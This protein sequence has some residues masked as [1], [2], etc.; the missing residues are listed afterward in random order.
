MESVGL[1]PFLIGR[2]RYQILLVSFILL[3]VFSA[4]SRTAAMGAGP[5][6]LIGFVVLF[7]AVYAMRGHRLHL[8]GASACTLI[9]IVAGSLAVWTEAPARLV[10]EV[11]NWGSLGLVLILFDQILRDLLQ[12]SAM[13]ADDILGAACGYCLLGLAS[14]RAFDLAQ[15][16]APGSFAIDGVPIQ[17]VGEAELLYYSFTVLTTLGFGDITPLAPIAQTLSVMEAAIGQMYL[18]VVV[19]ALVGR[20]LMRRPPADSPSE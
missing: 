16:Y 14:M 15:I 10:G 7:A 1:I 19:A 3:A 18:T 9:C 13:H 17:S 4:I 2:G 11:Y 6:R 8:I 5:I 20:V 12:R